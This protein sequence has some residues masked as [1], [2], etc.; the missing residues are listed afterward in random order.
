MK[1]IKELNVL[2]DYHNNVLILCTCYCKGDKAMLS[3]WSSYKE[4]KPYTDSHSDC[5]DL[6]S[7]YMDLDHCLFPYELLFKVS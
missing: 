1:E 6:F 2:V 3:S 7:K 4:T 5:T